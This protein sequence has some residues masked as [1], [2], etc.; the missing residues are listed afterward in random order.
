M[1]QRRLLLFLLSIII[2]TLIGVVASY[3]ANGYRFDSDKL[4]FSPNGLLVAN[5]D[6][7]GA[8]IFVNGELKTATNATIPL[9]PGTYDI[10]LKKE[11]YHLWQKR[12]TIDKEVVTQIDATLFPAAPSVSAITFSGAFTPNLSPDQTKLAYGVPANTKPAPQSAIDQDNGG[13]WVI[14]TINLPIGFNRE[15]RRITDGDLQEST[16]MWS[17]DSR[18]ILLDT[19][20]G[21]F[22]LNV[23]EF[24]PQ[25]KRVNIAAT[26][27]KILATW[28]AE[29]QK[30]LDSQLNRVPD[31]LSSLLEA[32]TKDLVFSPDETKI[33]YTASQSAQLKAEYAKPLPGASSQRQSRLVQPNKRY[34]YDIKEDRNFEIGDQA[35]PVYWLPNSRNLVRPE[36]DKVVI[37]DYDGTNP[38]VVYS[39]TYVAGYAFPTPNSGRMYILTN[40]GSQNTSPNLYTL[41]LK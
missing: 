17:P 36:K 12:M 39:G 34:V 1:T 3:Y 6:P 31:E 20:T 5:S 7:N 2:V 33:L 10:T 13:L 23:G 21:S 41:S 37:I 40:L 9:A 35:D 8:Q 27:T 24:T 29:A 11:S 18:Q 19:K 22:L 38:Q 26:K 30:R 4:K 28:T 16:W 25:T 32:K 15:P 14:E